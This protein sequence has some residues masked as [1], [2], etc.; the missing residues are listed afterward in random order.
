M[1]EPRFVSP[2]LLVSVR[3]VAEAE[4][5]L[6]GGADW[7]DLKEPSAGPLGAVGAQT[8]RQ[9]V[10]FLA[11]RRPVSA[12]LGEL[13]H[14]ETSPARQLLEVPGIEY[15]KL[16]LAGCTEIDSWR[17]DWRSV[18][19]QVVAAGK[20]LVAIVY[21]DWQRAH[22]PAPEQILVLAGQTSSRYLL[23]DTFDKQSP[24]TLAC[25]GASALEELV[26]LARR[27]SLRTVLA[28]G[29]TTEDFR[30]LPAIGFEMLAVRGAVCPAGRCSQVDERLVAKFCNS[31]A[32]HRLVET[33]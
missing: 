1:I 11:S 31:L 10:E 21:A 27:Q 9:V 28:G 15:V 6:S 30:D 12:A 32:A 29:I 5:A 19:S 24:G 3:D 14:W 4:A 8:A 22:A 16:G 18:E 25:L 17:D 13:A 2:K 20:S 23:I 7:I 26:R 33:A